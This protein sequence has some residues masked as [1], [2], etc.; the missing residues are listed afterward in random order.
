MQHIGAL[1]QRSEA[2]ATCK[3]KVV[4]DNADRVGC[5]NRCQR[6]CYTVWSF[7]HAGDNWRCAIAGEGHCQPGDLREAACA[8][9]R[10]T[11]RREAVEECLFQLC[12][13]DGFDHRAVAK[14]QYAEHFTPGNFANA[15]GCRWWCAVEIG[16]QTA[17][18]GEGGI[19]ARILQ[20][21]G[22]GD[23]IAHRRF[24]ETRWRTLDIELLRAD[25]LV[26]Q[27]CSLRIGIINNRCHIGSL[28]NTDILGDTSCDTCPFHILPVNN[29]LHHRI[30]GTR[31]QPLADHNT[32]LLKVGDAVGV[33]RQNHIYGCV[34]N[35]IGNGH[36][37]PIP[38]GRCNA[39]D[40]IVS[41]RSTFVDQHK[42]DFHTHL[43]QFFRFAADGADG[44]QELKSSCGT[45]T[46]QF[47]C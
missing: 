33:S 44:W 22:I 18:I 13:S 9:G 4:G 20:T 36:N 42:L 3:H 39:V 40:C 47:G 45:G 28:G 29:Q 37:R 34:L 27:D 12:A 24:K 2:I 5:A 19:H 32:T 43:A 16:T 11:D 1:S 23:H 6:T 21:H 26:A 31:I 10:V 41:Q 8:N 25:D 38:R 15:F 17:R 30:A 14:G 46:D 7:P 35:A